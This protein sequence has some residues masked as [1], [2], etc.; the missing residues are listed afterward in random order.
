MTR[1]AIALLPLFLLNMAAASAQQ[2]RPAP[3][4]AAA[5]IIDTQTD[6]QMLGRDILKARVMSGTSKDAQSFGLIEDLLFDQK[7]RIVAALV[8]V[9]GFL[10]IGQKTVA[11]SWESLTRTDIQIGPITFV[12]ALTREQFAAAPAF[13]SAEARKV[14]EQKRQVLEKARQL[15]PAPGVQSQP[16]PA[17]KVN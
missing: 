8:G 7:G 10:G 1:L 4:K 12:T 6:S 14:A 5:T 2:P 13:V 15:S 9:G 3:A 17:P 11:V 16:A